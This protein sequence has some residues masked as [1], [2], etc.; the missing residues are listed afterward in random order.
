VVFARL[1]QG[2]GQVTFYVDVRFAPTQRLIH[3]SSTHMLV[4]PDRDTVVEMAL[5]LK[6]VRFPQPGIYLVELF[7]DASWVADARILAR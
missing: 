1:H 4:F 3:L 5:T 7:C 2:L 6:G